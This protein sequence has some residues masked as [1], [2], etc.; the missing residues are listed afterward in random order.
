MKL[1]E[2]QKAIASQLIEI[3]ARAISQ[4]QPLAE[5]TKTLAMAAD[6][7]QTMQGNDDDN[8]DSPHPN[9]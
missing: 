6:L 8:A 7:I 5:A 9:V 1:T 3:G 4:Q 2:D